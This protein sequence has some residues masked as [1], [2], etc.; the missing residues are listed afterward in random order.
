MSKLMILSFASVIAFAL[1]GCES[2][3]TT[4]IRDRDSAG[5]RTTVEKI[6]GEPDDPKDHDKDKTI[7]IEHK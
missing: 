2:H 3:E 5:P 1:A 4:V 7:I 6:H